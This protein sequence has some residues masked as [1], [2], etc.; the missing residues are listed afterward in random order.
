[1]NVSPTALRSF[2][3]LLLCLILS[4]GA[5][6]IFNLHSAAAAH[7]PTLYFTQLMWFGIGLS[8]LVVAMLPDYR[9]SEHFAY[10]LYAVVC[11]LLLAVLLQGRSAGGARRWLVVGAL[12]FQPSELAK[13]AVVLCLARYL[14]AKAPAGG[15]TISTLIR[16]LN[17]SRPVAVLV[18]VGVGWEGAWL[19]DPVGEF[20]RFL[21]ER[22]PPPEIGDS[23]SLGITLV[24]VL[25]A[26]AVV[27]GWRIYRR[28]RRG[29]LLNPWSSGRFL[30]VLGGMFLLLLLL[31]GGLWWV[32]E[33]PVIR[34]PVG[35]LF[36]YL[37]GQ[38][39]PGGSY[40]TADPG[41]VVP[42]VLLLLVLAYLAAAVGH[43]RNTPADPLDAFLAPADLLLVPAVLILAQPDLGTAGI[44]L[45]VGATMILVVGVRRRS[46]VLMGGL[47]LVFA[48][49]AWSVILKDYQRQ[50]ILTFMDPENDIQGAGWNA[51]QSMIAVGSGRWWGK[52]HLGGTQSQL[53]FLPEQHTDFAFS[54]WA[55]EQG[56]MG[57]LLVVV[58]YLALLLVGFSV[59]ANARELYGTLLATGVV[60]IVLW[61]TIINIA[62]V[63]GVMP[64]VGLTLPL[65]SYGGSS[66]LTVLLGL[67]L[68]L[69][70]HW[71]RRG[72]R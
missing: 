4:V 9:V 2:P 30:Q 71:R 58:L 25:L 65:F 35:S 6:G 18:L 12:S 67:A 72:R 37:H 46:L 52:G 21:R 54:V 1:M 44:V 38:A 48:R 62:M 24:S 49:L 42:V 51:V 70:V 3:W 17:I 20:A 10:V 15:Y 31:G 22:S 50:R 45:L 14:T 5:L 7:D 36:R 27:G 26:V 11:L 28:S 63:I 34:D 69:N 43:L 33:W 61:Q 8:L 23:P 40:A 56:F 66:L 68:L 60:A 13:L 39:A 55:E 47:S 16:P 41:L 59:A 57:C 64:V 32:W 29:D 19:Q 53:S